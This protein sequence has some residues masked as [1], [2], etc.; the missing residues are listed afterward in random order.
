MDASFIIPCKGRLTHLQ[1]TLPYKL[2][3]QTHYTYE[4]IIV[5]YNCPN[6]TEEWCNRL[7]HNLVRVVRVP[8]PISYFNNSH[9][10][11]CGAAEALGD[12]LCFSDADCYLSPEW[13]DYVMDKITA[14]SWINGVGNDFKPHDKQ[15]GRGTW[16]CTK[17]LW[18]SLQG[19]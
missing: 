15:Q 8:A 12:V 7:H 16:A 17:E 4:V 3:Q 11:N 10:R 6:F 14:K 18:E 1:E 2:V 9:C 13:L 19:S 5:D